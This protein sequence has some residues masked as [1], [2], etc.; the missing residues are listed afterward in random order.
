[1]LV[2]RDEQLTSELR[3]I[4]EREKRPVE[5]VL[6]SMVAQYPSESI[7]EVSRPDKSEVIKRVRR[8]IY[9]EARQYWESIGDTF[10]ASM[11]DEELDE[12]FG[13]FDEEG[14]PRLKSELPSLD[15]PPGSPAYAAIIAERGGLDSGNPD[16]AHN[17]KEILNA[18]FAEDYL[19]RQR[20]EDGGR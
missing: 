20:G 3:Q 13:A 5:D 19:K 8:K 1:M 4:A 11:T 12:E 17:S 14:I 16:L 18:H 2:I 7:T 6:K 9:A 15:P 10:K